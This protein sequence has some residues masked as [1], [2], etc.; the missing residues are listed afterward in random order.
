M[1]KI[2]INLKMTLVTLGMP[3]IM[4]K[5]KN[6]R[7][8]CSKDL[9]LRK[10]IRLACIRASTWFIVDIILNAGNLRL[11]VVISILRAQKK[12]DN[13]A[14]NRDSIDW[15]N[16]RMKRR[17]LLRLKLVQAQ[18]TTAKPFQKLPSNNHH[19]QTHLR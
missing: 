6:T 4:R 12:K 18:T 13:V 17:N 8:L 15:R 2:V 7:S 3:K 14:S 9:I 1:A 10:I 16:S 5:S 19:R 11:S